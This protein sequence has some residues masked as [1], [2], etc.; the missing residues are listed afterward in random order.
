MSYSVFL[1][2]LLPLPVWIGL[3]VI[4]ALAAG[5]GLLRGLRGWAWRMAAFLLLLGALL[6]PQ[7]LREERILKPDI[8]LLLKD[9]TASNRLAGRIARLEAAETVLEQT[10]QRQFGAEVRK[11]SIEDRKEEGTALFAALREALAQEPAGQIAAVIA[12]SDGQ[13][14]DRPLPGF[15]FPAPFHL[16]LTGEKDE[17]DRKLEI[18]NA[19]AFAIL[20]EP[21]TVTLKIE[22]SGA[23]TRADPRADVFISV[24][25]APPTQF[26][27]PV[28]TEVDVELSALHGG[29]NIF[30]FRVEPLAGEVSESNNAAM[31]S[32]NGVRERLR[33]LLV[34][35]EPHPGTRTWRNLLKS[36]SSVDLVHFTILRPPEKQDGVPVDELSLIAFPTRQLFLEKIDDFDLIIFDRYKRRGIL[37]PAYLQNIVRYVGDGGAVLVAA[38]P[39]Y[40]S[41]N[42]LFRSPLQ[43]ILPGA[44]TA[45]VIE[46]GVL[47]AL[48]EF[49]QRHPVTAQLPETGD[50]GR[51][52]RQIELLPLEGDVILKG[53]QD[54]P[55]LTLNRFKAGRVALLASDHAWLW[56]RNF[57]G[58][59]PQQEL[60]RRLAHWLMSEPELEEEALRAEQMEEG[61]LITRRSLNA[62]VDPVEVV[63]PSGIS[64]KLL[65]EERAPGQFQGLYKNTQTGLF[66]MSDGALTRAFAIGSATPKEFEN[67]LSTASLMMPIIQ[68]SSGGV[69]WL[70]EGLPR[71]R[72]VNIGRAAAGRGWLGITPRQAYEN[73]QLSQFSLVPGWL[74][75]FL[76]SLI[77]MLAW[78]REGRKRV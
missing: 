26:N 32:V 17:F 22:E 27:L 68:E 11:I 1:D 56:D 20:G 60:L 23:V 49:G 29:E 25:G 5:L 73:V 12:L 41:A 19:P 4:C 75:A 55:L 10:L 64:Q 36:D 3:L 46:N 14:H 65:L 44:P 77:G 24:D 51:W 76:V 21:V 48:T 16:L 74:A 45:Q 72:A 7:L 39:E 37:P 58:G 67:P 28:G 30:E 52:M 13:V 69:F 33:V 70:Q 71:V 8:V 18:K 63:A 35:G 38:G 47:P 59:G 9:Q 2:P 57:E 31:L 15:S 53:V 78:L 54:L 62:V 42:S 34:S 66:K 43:P 61:V 6:N 50:W 40:A